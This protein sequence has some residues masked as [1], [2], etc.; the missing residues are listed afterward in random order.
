VEE[1]LT[2][3]VMLVGIL[4][5]ILGFNTDNYIAVAVGVLLILVP[6]ALSRRRDD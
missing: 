2:D 5:L 3:L 4:S 6:L 1:A